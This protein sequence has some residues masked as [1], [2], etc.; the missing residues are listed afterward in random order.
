MKLLDIFKIIL[1]ESEEKIDPYHYQNTHGER[2][3]SSA[4][5]GSN[6][7]RYKFENAGDILR[8]FSKYDDGFVDKNY[9]FE[10]LN[11]IERFLQQW[12]DDEFHPDDTYSTI[13]KNNPEL[14]KNIKK[15][16]EDQPTISK[17]QDLAVKLTLAL[18]NGNYQ[19]AKKYHDLIRNHYV[20]LVKD[21]AKK[22]AEH[23]GTKVNPRIHY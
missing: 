17:A 8:E 10:K 21:N 13:K 2:I 22:A 7:W 15:A 14:L 6:V 1:K 12:K 4:W 9:V 11:K 19:D 20:I 18:I 5:K 16:Y 23:Y 3:V